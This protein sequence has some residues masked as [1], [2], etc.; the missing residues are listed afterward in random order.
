M[1]KNHSNSLI[2]PVLPPLRNVKNHSISLIFPVLPPL[3]NV[4]IHSKSLVFSVLSPLRNIKKPLK[5]SVP[6]EY[7]LI[8][9]CEKHSFLSVFSVKTALQNPPLELKYRNIFQ[10][11]QKITP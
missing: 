4:E 10:I 11:F 9:Q 3:R 1:L 6:S 2:F 7:L 8:F 5:K